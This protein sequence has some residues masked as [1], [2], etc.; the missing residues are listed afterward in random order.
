[1][2]NKNQLFLS[3]LLLLLLLLLLPLPFL[4][5]PFLSLSLSRVS[6]QIGSFFLSSLFKNFLTPI[7]SFFSLLSFYSQ[8]CC[9]GDA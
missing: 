9:A 6:L 3:L 7:S 2:R 8:G 4:F 5:F 1:M